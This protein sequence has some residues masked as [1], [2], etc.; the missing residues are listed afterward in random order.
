MNSCAKRWVKFFR[1]FS[2]ITLSISCPFLTESEDGTDALDLCI[3]PTY[4]LTDSKICDFTNP[5][6]TL[7]NTFY[8]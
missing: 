2:L 6:D 4:Y 8:F 7:I 3:K 5:I 1:S